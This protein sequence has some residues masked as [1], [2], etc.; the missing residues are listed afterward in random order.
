MKMTA[1]EFLFPSPCGVWVVSLMAGKT[2]IK[3]DEFPSPCGGVSCFP[4]EIEVYK[5]PSKIPSPYGVWVVSCNFKFD[6]Y[7]AIRF[8]PLSGGE[9][10][11]ST[12]S[13]PRAAKSFRPLAGCE[14]FPFMNTKSLKIGTSPSPCGV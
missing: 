2:Q 8:R 9:L 10:F 7:Y 13:L 14:S 5:K 6:V 3:T 11:R 12:T 4:F 1:K